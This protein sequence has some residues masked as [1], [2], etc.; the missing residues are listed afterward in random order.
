MAWNSGDGTAFVGSRATATPPAPVGSK[1]ALARSPLA[2]AACTRFSVSQPSDTKRW[3]SSGSTTGVR[4]DRSASMEIDCSWSRN[5]QHCVLWLDGASVA[6]RTNSRIRT[7]R[8][9]LFAAKGSRSARARSSWLAPGEQARHRQCRAAGGC[10]ENK[11]P[12]HQH[13]DLARR[14]K[15]ATSMHPALAAFRRLFDGSSGGTGSDRFGRRAR[16]RARCPPRPWTPNSGLPRPARTGFICMVRPFDRGL[17]A[18]AAASG[19]P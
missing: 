8:S 2:R 15:S 6:Y 18:A 19:V 9:L 14:Q 4:R 17:C 13:D 12:E 3:W 11:I 7:A 5:F 10:G 16:M 1:R